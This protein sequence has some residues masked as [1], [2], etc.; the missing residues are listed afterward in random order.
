MSQHR[1]SPRRGRDAG[2][3]IL[4]AAKDEG[5]AARIA[6]RFFSPRMSR[7]IRGPVPKLTCGK[8]S[9]VESRP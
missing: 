5:L 7:H 9:L 3:K 6:F 8:V 4:A 2:V 1:A